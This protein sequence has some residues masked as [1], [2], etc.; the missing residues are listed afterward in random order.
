MCKHAI[1]EQVRQ[2]AE[3]SPDSV[4]LIGTAKTFT[5]Q[6]L[7]E[8]IDSYR[9]RF[10]V[11]PVER[12]AIDLENGPAWAVIDLAL[13]GAN[14]ISIPVPAFF[15]QQ[16]LNHLL[17]DAAVE[18]LLTTTPERYA[19][20]EG[21]STESFELCGEHIQLIHFKRAV[22]LLN[23][24]PLTDLDDLGDTKVPPNRW[25]EIGGS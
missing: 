25:T 10:R 23:A 19:E 18:W 6:Q 21:I 14:K 24:S 9:E 12:F 1:V 2:V 11:L 20:C 5:Y 4:A 13:M 22:H 16:Q 3:Q 8:L 7:I 17:K 15:S